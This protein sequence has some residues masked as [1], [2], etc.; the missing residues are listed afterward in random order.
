MSKTLCKLKKDLP[1]NLETM[2]QLA[3][4]P[5]HICKDCGR[6]SNNESSLCSPKKIDKI[7]SKQPSE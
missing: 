2:L 5:T 3:L 4:N 6:V 7:L 1:K